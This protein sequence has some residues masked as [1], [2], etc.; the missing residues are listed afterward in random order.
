MNELET[1]PSRRLELQELLEGIVGSRNV[2]FQP[3][4]SM[5][6][7]YPCII[8]QFDSYSTDNADDILY[9]EEKRYQVTYI[10]K[11]PDTNIPE[12][13]HRLEYCYFDRFYTSSNLN[14]YV[15]RLYF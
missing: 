7:K 13:L 12:I 10:D 3:P 5:R 15:F 1:P 9:R 14:H 2:Y 8:Y 4:E 11:N 6:I